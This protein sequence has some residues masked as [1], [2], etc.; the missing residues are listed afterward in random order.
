M[1]QAGL[2]ALTDLLSPE[3]KACLRAGFPRC[4]WGAQPEWGIASS[5][6]VVCLL[7]GGSPGDPGG[8]LAFISSHGVP[9]AAGCD[10]VRV[11]GV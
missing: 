10:S 8:T 7:P 2:L 5:A 4:I 11:A 1:L 6:I 9:A 3:G